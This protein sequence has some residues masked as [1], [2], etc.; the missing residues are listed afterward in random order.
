MGNR[1][2]GICLHL[3]GQVSKQPKRCHSTM[4]GEKDRAFY[5][6]SGSLFRNIFWTF[7][8]NSKIF[9]NREPETQQIWN[10]LPIFYHCAKRLFLGFCNTCR[11]HF[12]C[13]ISPFVFCRK[14]CYS[15]TLMT[16]FPSFFEKYCQNECFAIFFWHVTC[17]FR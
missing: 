17:G 1:K 15:W 11:R 16:I 13:I 12:F 6:V 3:H 2:D 5:C 7:L 4:L 10:L 14:T 9:L 8:S